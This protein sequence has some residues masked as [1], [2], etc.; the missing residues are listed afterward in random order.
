MNLARALEKLHLAG[1]TTNRHFLV[2]TLRHEN[3]LKGETTT[4]FIEDNSPEPTLQLTEVEIERAA[5]SVALWMQSK[6]RKN[7]TVLTSIPSGWRNG[8]LPAQEVSLLH[9]GEKITVSYKTKRD[10]S[11]IFNNGS[12]AKIYHCSTEHIEAEI[13]GERMVSLI[14]EGQENIHLQIDQ[15]TVS[16]RTL[17]R[18]EPPILQIAEGSLIAPMPGVVLEIKVS[19]GDTVSAGDTL[20]TLEAMKMEHHVKAPYEGTVVE[21]LV[22]ENQQLDNGVPLLVINPIDKNKKGN[23]G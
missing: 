7:A 15:G 4:D 1:V 6:N 2:S 8:R 20:L 11:F 17:P 22:S 18:F 23:N 3:F 5:I 14:T 12:T 10:G 16:F 9:S 21:I 13:D 19:S